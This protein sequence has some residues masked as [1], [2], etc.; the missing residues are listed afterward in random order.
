MESWLAG[1]KRI[2]VW[3]GAALVLA[4]PVTGQDAPESKESVTLLDS[5]S[6]RSVAFDLLGRPPYREEREAWLGKPLAAFVEDCLKGEEFWSSWVEEQLYY[7]LLID[8]F[9]PRSERV[10]SLPRR[11]RSGSMNVAE[12]LHVIALC[13]SF[14]R[15]NPG[16]DTFVTVVMEQ[17]LG[18]HVQRKLND[19]EAGKR[20]YDGKAGSF[21]GLK[22]KSQSDVVRIALEDR[23]MLMHFLGREYQR[24]MR[25]E[26]PKRE[27]GAWSRALAKGEVSYAQILG[28]WISSPAYSKRLENSVKM[29]NRIFVQS[30]YVDL[31]N[32]K[33]EVNEARRLRNALDGLSSAGPLR[34]VIARL[35]IDSGQVEFKQRKDISDP[36][37]WI[38][39]LFQRLLGRQP[40]S[41]ELGVFVES[42]HDPACKPATIVHALISH[43]EYQT[44]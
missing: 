42:F 19:L 3:W 35:Y 1:L 6:L 8:N 37:Q 38:A 4:G 20:L 2:L 7:F 32:E 21:L 36:T 16:P 34:A 25:E 28:T 33:P 39:K 29:T 31:S 43:P 41:A 18:L 12:G 9:R 30:L 10:L 23:R 22:G 24:V 5:G 14:D 44:W 40:T 11:M 15:R 17:F 27:L 13:A 26:A